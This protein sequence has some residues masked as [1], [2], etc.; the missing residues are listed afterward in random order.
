MTLTSLS[1]SVE[2]QYA[3]PYTGRG[4]PCPVSSGKFKAQLEALFIVEIPGPSHT[5]SHT[6]QMGSKSL[7]QYSR[8]LQWWGND[9]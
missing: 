1:S 2:G 4:G 3:G 8:T 5:W 9:I 7:L 6:R